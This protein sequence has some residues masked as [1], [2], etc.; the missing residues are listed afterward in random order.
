MK[1]SE[2]LLYKMTFPCTVL[3]VLMFKIGEWFPSFPMYALNPFLAIT[4]LGAIFSLWLAILA[5]LL[6]K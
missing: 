6:N 5:M 4:F 1:E 2:R 3:S